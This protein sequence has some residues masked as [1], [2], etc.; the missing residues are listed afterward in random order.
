MAYEIMTVKH[1]EVVVQLSGEDGN[2]FSIA[3]RVGKA[4]RRAHVSSD[5]IKEFYSAVAA[6]SS[7]DHALC[8][9]MEWVTTK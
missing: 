7:Y 1:P 9:V 5:E 3:G 8:T 6:S 2:I 4:L